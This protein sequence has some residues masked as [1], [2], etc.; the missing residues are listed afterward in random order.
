[1]VLGI[2]YS[3]CSSWECP[4]FPTCWANMVSC[5]LP[6]SNFFNYHTVTLPTCQ[7]LWWAPLQ[8]SQN[9]TGIS[10]NW[11]N[12]KSV[13]SIC[14]PLSIVNSACSWRNNVFKSTRRNSM[15]ISYALKSAGFSMCFSLVSILRSEQLFCICC[16]ANITLL[17][18]M[19]NTVN[20]SVKCILKKRERQRDRQQE[21]LLNL[22]SKFGSLNFM[23]Y[24]YYCVA[25]MWHLC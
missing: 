9:S 16:S 22:Q 12:T 8:Y 3:F 20:F 25:T 1:M 4:S 11:L 23:F 7:V 18:F 17:I 15:C 10:F 13:N 19:Y 6:S 2:T 21:D 14:Y 24:N 5:D